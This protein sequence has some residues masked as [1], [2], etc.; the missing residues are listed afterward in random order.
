MYRV[1]DRTDNILREFKT[2]KEAETFCI[3]RNRYDW[4]IRKP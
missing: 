1:I 2:L 4:K 3:S